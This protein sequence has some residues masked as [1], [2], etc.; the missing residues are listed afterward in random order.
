VS[1]DG[2]SQSARVADWPNTEPT[3]LEPV[4]VSDRI[5]PGWGAVAIASLAGVLLGWLLGR[6][7]ASGARR[8]RR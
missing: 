4:W 2:H 7:E 5:V 8:G 6:Q 3:Q 1:T